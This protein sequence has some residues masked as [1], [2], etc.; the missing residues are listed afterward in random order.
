ML[1]YS[2]VVGE[3]GRNC[4][5]HCA[6]GWPVIARS[7]GVVRTEKGREHERSSP[8]LSVYSLLFPLWFGGGEVGGRQGYVMTRRSSGCFLVSYRRDYEM[9]LSGGSTRVGAYPFDVE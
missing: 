8:V 5:L 6:M 3:G 1:P 7:T 4:L 2:F 9:I